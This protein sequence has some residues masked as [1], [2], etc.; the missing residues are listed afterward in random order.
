MQGRILLHIF[1][2]LLRLSFFA[3]RGAQHRA[4]GQRRQPAEALLRSAF[5]ALDGD[6]DGA[7][8]P[9]EWATGLPVLFRGS[10]LEKDEAVFALLQS[11]KGDPS[12]SEPLQM[13]SPPGVDRVA[14]G[15]GLP[16]LELHVGAAVAALTRGGALLGIQ[17]SCKE[18]V[19][20]VF[21]SSS[22][23]SSS[24]VATTVSAS[25]SSSPRA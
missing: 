15:L 20:N 2:L 22:S 21:S 5:E 13:T 11:W 1:F 8:S 12:S 23:S 3:R 14:D 4:A 7:L 10:L 19:E 17:R 9:A 18:V 24:S 6:G 16:E 25:S